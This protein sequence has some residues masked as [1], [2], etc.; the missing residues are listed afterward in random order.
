MS[1]VEA[2]S[3]PQGRGEATALPAVMNAR[4]QYLSA[5][6]VAKMH[7]VTPSAVYLWL[8]T[9][10]LPGKLV[11]DGGYKRWMIAKKDAETFVPPQPRLRQR[12]RRLKATNGAATA[13]MTPQERGRVGAAARWGKRGP[14]RPRKVATSTTTTT[15]A[16]P[17]LAGGFA[18]LL[19]EANRPLTSQV[20]A[21]QTSV[22]EM[23]VDLQLL[24]RFL[25][26]R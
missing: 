20:E 13:P 8:A 6:R 16:A 22:D 15:S 3:A 12:R 26:G 21:L 7:H 19:T 5:N 2:E 23:K 1:V 25:Q 4:E 17:S 18:A 10:I 14:G 11:S 24:L 9:K